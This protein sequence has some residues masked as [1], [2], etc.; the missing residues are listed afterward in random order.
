MVPKIRDDTIHELGGVPSVRHQL[1]KQFVIGQRLREV[2]PQCRI[3]IE[4][5]TIRRLNAVRL[6]EDLSDD[7]EDLLD[8]LLLNNSV[9]QRLEPARSGPLHLNHFSTREIEVVSFLALVAVKVGV[10]DLLNQHVV[11]FQI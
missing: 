11:S 3:L 2:D 10:R 1:H 6:G 9:E 7:I 4:P 5:S 8:I